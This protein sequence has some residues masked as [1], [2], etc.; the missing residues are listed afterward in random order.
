MQNQV[1]AEACGQLCSKNNEIKTTSLS[2]IA[3]LKNTRKAARWLP[4]VEN[5]LQSLSS[6]TLTRSKIPEI[7]DA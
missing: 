5:L 7:R 4:R 1:V 3:V 6:V 2:F